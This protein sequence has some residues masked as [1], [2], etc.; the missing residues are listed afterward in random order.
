M[1]TLEAGIFV[2]MLA[3]AF[4]FM[5]WAWIT[6]NNNTRGGLGAGFFYILSM[7]L[8]LGMSIFVGSGYEVAATSTMTDGS[9]TWTEERVL[10][11]EGEEGFWFTWVFTGLAVVNIFL[12]VRAVYSS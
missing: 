5:A 11:P 12:F 8:F 9:T 6:T 3:F 7:V 10:I 4:G 2:M 1:A